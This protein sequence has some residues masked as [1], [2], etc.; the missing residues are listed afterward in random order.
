MRRENKGSL[1]FSC[2]SPKKTVKKSF[3]QHSCNVRVNRTTFVQHSCCIL[4]LSSDSSYDSSMNHQHES[5]DDC[6]ME[7][8]LLHDRCTNHRNVARNVHDYCTKQSMQARLLHKYCTITTRFTRSLYDYCTNIARKL[9][10]KCTIC[11]NILEAPR[12]RTWFFQ[13]SHNSHE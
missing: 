13:D 10:D 6:T 1:I 9:D 2:G 8:R 11:T 3:V 5:Y 12:G 4:F 7:G